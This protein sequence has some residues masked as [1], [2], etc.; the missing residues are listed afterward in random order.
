MIVVGIWMRRGIAARLAPAVLG[1]LAFGAW[2]RVG[3]Q[4]E[5][6]WGTRVVVVLFPLIAPL[7]AAAVA[8]DTVRH[9]QPLLSA[10][11]PSTRR[12]RHAS[13]A[14]VGAHL[15]WASACFCTVLVAAALRLLSNDAI[16]RP[17]LWILPEAFAALA[18]AAAFGHLVGR[19]VSSL[20]APPLAAVLVFGA[21][22]LT[23]P[24]GLIAL[25]VPTPVVSSAV[26]L[27]RD[28]RAA[29][30]AIA[31]NAASAIVCLFLA[32]RGPRATRPTPSW[33]AGTALAVLSLVGLI[34]VPASATP[35]EYRAASLVRACVTERQ[36]EVCGPSGATSF[37]RDLSGALAD[38][39][40]ALRDSGL[41]LPLTYTLGVAGV[42]PPTDRPVAQVSPA[43]LQEQPTEAVVDM[44]SSPRVCPQMLVPDEDTTLLLDRRAQ[45]RTW[46]TSALGDGGA[47]APAAVRQAYDELLRCRLRR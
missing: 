3:W 20:A 22:S 28:P 30:M 21:E 31:L 43:L 11:G 4:Q 5:W 45:V 1:A 8:Y 13:L 42:A 17:D 24:F 16:G 23:L 19:V 37:L 36:V 26:G 33:T 40:A 2:S 7:V 6:L 32:L 14:L 10:L 12:W 9:W 39:L 34:A 44:L 47:R 38:D 25:F 29:G 15:L 27:A 46:L 35:V 18:A 41:P